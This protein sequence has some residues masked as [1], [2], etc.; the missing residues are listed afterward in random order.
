MNK[1]IVKLG[2]RE[3]RQLQHY[4]GSPLYNNVLVLDGSLFNTP[5]L[6]V[7]IWQT[8]RS[9]TTKKAINYLHFTFSLKLTGKVA[10]FFIFFSLGDKSKNLLLIVVF[11]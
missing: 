6:T 1:L 3:L 8:I 9:Y 5:V 7:S 10:F 4:S 11:I 2:T